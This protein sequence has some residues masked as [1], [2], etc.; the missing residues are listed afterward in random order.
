M[1]VIVQKKSLY[2][3]LISVAVGLFPTISFSQE[4]LNAVKKVENSEENPKKSKLQKTLKRYYR[5]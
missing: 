2:T 3:F 4:N 1:L 5:Q